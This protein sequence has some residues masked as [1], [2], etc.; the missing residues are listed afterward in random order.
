MPDSMLMCSEWAVS[1]SEAKEAPIERAKCLRS[2]WA[3]YRRVFDAYILGGN[4][5]L[6]FWHGTPEMNP[7]ALVD[8]LGQYYMS[9][10]GKA[11]YPGPFD[12]Q[13][14]P[15]LDYRGSI[16][17]QYNPIAIAQYGLGNH[18]LY[19]QI[20]S[21]EAYRK[22]LL[23][24]DWLTDHLEPN[25]WGVPV[26]NHNFNFEYRDVPQFTKGCSSFYT[27]SR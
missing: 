1:A 6:T 7:E 15:L 21:G 24:A 18:N 13:G 8:R 23:S 9:F 20:G 25:S 26:W 12:A 27:I 19:C 2:K 11:A 10:A 14:I 3:Y 4:S 22:F 5:H 17:R 16:G